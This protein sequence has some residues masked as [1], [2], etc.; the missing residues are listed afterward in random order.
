M[1]ESQCRV[2]SPQI[3][4][5]LWLK[6]AEQE[7]HHGKG[8]RAALNGLKNQAVT[9]ELLSGLPVTAFSA[10]LQRAP[11]L[12][13]VDR[14]DLHSRDQKNGRPGSI[15]GWGTFFTPNRNLV[16]NRLR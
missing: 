9:G 7:E 5:R 6:Q 8:S 10:F 1:P 2:N 4:S 13:L 14:R 16:H 15:P 11:V 3:C 12:E